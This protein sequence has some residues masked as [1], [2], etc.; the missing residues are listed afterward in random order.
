Q[1]E[2]TA[3]FERAD[4]A[5]ARDALERVA[6]AKPEN[7]AVLYNLACAL[8]QT[9]EADAAAE[10]LTD[11][12]SYGFVDFLHMSRDPHLE[13]L[14]GHAVY[15]RVVAGWRELLDARGDAN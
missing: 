11:A 3:A 4:F 2:A 9:G 8:A 12:I 10:R 13:P 7:P 5:A 6:A 14:R 15:R 1:R